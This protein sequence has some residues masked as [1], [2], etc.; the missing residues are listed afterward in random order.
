MI[1]A[2]TQSVEKRRR[3]ET[4]ASPV[5]TSDIL[6]SF[7][8]YVPGSMVEGKSTFSISAQVASPGD[9]KAVT[10][11]LSGDDSTSCLIGNEFGR[12]L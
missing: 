10:A 5:S 2:V 6:D 11:T 1:D 8:S 12:T 3:L 7:G 4:A 9:S